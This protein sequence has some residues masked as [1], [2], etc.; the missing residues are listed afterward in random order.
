MNITVARLENMHT[1]VVLI[2]SFV[3]SRIYAFTRNSDRIPT[4]CKAES[5]VIVVVKIT[6]LS[7]NSVHVMSRMWRAGGNCHRHS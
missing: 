2:V 7:L 1:V 4:V 6:A 3:S 5:R